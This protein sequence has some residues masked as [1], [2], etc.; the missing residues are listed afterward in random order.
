MF[1]LLSNFWRM[2]LAFSLSSLALC[3]SSSASSSSSMAR[4]SSVVGLSDLAR[5]GLQILLA[6]AGWGVSSSD[7][8]SPSSMS[9]CVE[10]T[11]LGIL[12]PLRILKVCSGGGWCSQLVGVAC[13]PVPLSSRHA[14]PK[15]GWIC[16]P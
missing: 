14:V 15:L 6:T 11:C 1:L 13:P 9:V 3:S 4:R 8:T 10:L 16:P 7:T 2:V 12:Y 5:L